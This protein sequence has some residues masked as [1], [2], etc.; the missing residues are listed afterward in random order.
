MKVSTKGGGPYPLFSAIQGEGYTPFPETL[1]ASGEKI[2]TRSLEGGVQSDPPPLS[3]FDTIHPID[4]KFDTYNKL[5]LYLQL[6]G[7]T[8]C[9]IG[10]HG[11][12]CQINDFTAA[13]FL[14]F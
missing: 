8:W 14:D 7:T 10:F 9:L 12:N 11:N 1:E 6:S 5:Y 3:T 13:A 2:I 4:L